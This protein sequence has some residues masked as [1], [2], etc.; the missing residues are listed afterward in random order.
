MEECSRKNDKL[1]S[2]KDLSWLDKYYGKTIDSSL[3][4]RL[5]IKIIGR[6]NNKYFTRFILKY[7]SYKNHNEYDEYDCY[8]DRLYL[9]LL[10]NN[11]IKKMG[12]I[13]FFYEHVLYNFSAKKYEKLTFNFSFLDNIYLDF[14]SYFNLFKENF[15]RIRNIRS[16]D[17]LSYAID[18]ELELDRKLYYHNKNYFLW[19]FINDQ[20]E[21]SSI[22]TRNEL[23][24]EIAL[25]SSSNM[26]KDLIEKVMKFDLILAEF[27][28]YRANLDIVNFLVEFVKKK[29]HNPDVKES[30]SSLY[31]LQEAIFCRFVADSGVKLEIDSKKIFYLMHNEDIIKRFNFIKIIRI[32]KYLNYYFDFD[33]FDINKIIE[34]NNEV[35]LEKVL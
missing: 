9:L 7:I 13:I 14:V 19:A 34:F 4:R 12:R 30:N 10:N 21:K 27:I 16:A 31:I 11:K 26:T 8:Y 20:D 6:Y 3:R 15:D 22:K 35:L 1:V 33:K 17:D 24:N 25:V 29:C 2:L 18:K 28:I 32:S 23:F 5:I